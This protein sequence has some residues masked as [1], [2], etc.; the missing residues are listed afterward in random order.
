MK[1]TISTKAVSQLKCLEERKKLRFT[2]QRKDLVLQFLV[3]LSDTFP[4]AMLE[5]N[6]ELCWE[7]KDLTNQNSLT[8]SEYTQDIHG[9]DWV[10]YC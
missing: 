2:L 9:R 5:M 4:V 7:E 8:L 3:R 6:L 1:D 10:Q